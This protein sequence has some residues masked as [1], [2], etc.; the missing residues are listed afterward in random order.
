MSNKKKKKS[1]NSDYRYLQKKN[2]EWR[3]EQ[4]R[5]ERKAEKKKNRWLNIASFV[6]ILGSV[7]MGISSYTTQNY[8]LAPIYTVTSGIGMMLM[9]LSSKNT[10]P[11]FYKVGMGMGFAMLL[12]AYYIARTT[13][14]IG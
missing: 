7:I 9:A 3:E 10:R 2:D 13:G 14:A 1:K 5:A 8:G 4:E 6:L 11:T 12:L